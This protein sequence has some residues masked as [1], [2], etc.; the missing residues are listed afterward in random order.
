MVAAYLADSHVVLKNKEKANFNNAIKVFVHCEQSEGPALHSFNAETL[1]VIKLDHKE[2]HKRYDQR[3][4]EQAASAL[5]E[6]RYSLPLPFLI[7]FVH[8]HHMVFCH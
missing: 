7:L 6:K 3:N 8:L 2:A 4:E 1:D 5:A